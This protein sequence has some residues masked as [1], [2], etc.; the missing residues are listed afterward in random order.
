MNFQT[1]KVSKGKEHEKEESLSELLKTR[2]SVATT[3]VCRT[4][5]KWASCKRSAPSKK[6]KDLMPPTIVNENSRLS[7]GSS[8]REECHLQGNSSLQQDRYTSSHTDTGG[9]HDSAGDWEENSI[10]ICLSNAHTPDKG[11]PNTSDHSMLNGAIS[12]GT[13]ISSQRCPRPET[14]GKSDSNPLTSMDRDISSFKSAYSRKSPRLMELKNCHVEDRNSPKKSR[15]LIAENGQGLQQFPNK[16]VEPLSSSCGNS[17]NDQRLRHLKNIM[18]EEAKEG[19][20]GAFRIQSGSGF[21]IDEEL[22]SP[23]STNHVS[24]DSYSGGKE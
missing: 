12:S 2:E 10:N 20:R 22:Q 17:R 16:W 21:S 11:C 1:L 9:S 4:L 24:H 5:Q 3:E 18:R 23:G 13:C 6:N 7:S 15:K 8:A 14:H 19:V